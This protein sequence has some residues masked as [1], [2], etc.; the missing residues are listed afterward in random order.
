MFL[1]Q[2]LVGQRKFTLKKGLQSLGTLWAHSAVQ[3]QRA[4]R[5]HPESIQRAL[6]LIAKRTLVCRTPC[7]TPSGALYV[8]IYHKRYIHSVY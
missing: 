4:P 8:T 6:T 2:P 7:L 3:T 5:E 1:K